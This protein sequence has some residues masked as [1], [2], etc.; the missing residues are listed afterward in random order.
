M[1][2]HQYLL[3]VLKDLRVRV[4]I[5]PRASD[6]RSICAHISDV[7]RPDGVDYFAV[8]KIVHDLFQAWPEFSG[9]R[10][11]PVPHPTGGR[12]MSIYYLAA[13][14]DMMWVGEYGASRKRL[15]NYMIEQLE[16][17]Q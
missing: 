5:D 8:D 7:K 10:S 15:L 9:H 4:E 3:N 12:V 13:S 17:D 14:H 16:V 2:A 1:T 6:L 11:F